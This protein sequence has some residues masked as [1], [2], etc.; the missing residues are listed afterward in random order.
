MPL[1]SKT[2]R[3][4]PSTSHFIFGAA[5]WL[6]GL[7]QPRAGFGLAYIDWAQQEFGI[8]A[9]FSDDE[10]MQQAYQSGDPYLA[11]AKQAGAVPQEGT[12]Q[13]HSAE[14][15]LFKQCVLARHI[16]TE[17]SLNPGH[18]AYPLHRKTL[19]DIGTWLCQNEAALTAQYGF[20]GLCEVLEVNPVHRTQVIEG[21][22]D[23]RQGISAIAFICA[24]EDSASVQ[25][26][27]HPAEC[28]DG[29]LYQAL[30]ETLKQLHSR[31]CFPEG[32][33]HSHPTEG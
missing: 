14:R 10:N 16:C 18:D 8:A 31:Q 19:F 23:V 20:E 6:R 9:G 28:K 11:F 27:R 12:A 4:Q 33:S 3:N 1:H 22:K 24:L 17:R 2:G 13:S 25:S 21:V 29:P 7:I 32:R 26:G 15:A 5:S 30:W